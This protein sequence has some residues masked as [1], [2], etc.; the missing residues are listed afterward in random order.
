[1]PPPV[2]VLKGAEFEVKQLWPPRA[3]REGSA[4]G[5]QGQ[6]HSQAGDWGLEGRPRAADV[7]NSPSSPFCV[8]PAPWFAWAREPQ[9]LSP[10]SA[11]TAFLRA[12][13]EPQ[14]RPASNKGCLG[15]VLCPVATVQKLLIIVEQGV[16]RFHFAMGPLKMTWPALPARPVYYSNVQTAGAIAPWCPRPPTKA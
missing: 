1:M 3:R 10:K 5:R 6:L 7:T 11:L 15:V 16:L 12:R 13:A 2:C 9:D 8:P 14:G 4:N